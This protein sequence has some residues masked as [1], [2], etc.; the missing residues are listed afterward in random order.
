MNLE[1]YRF[2]FYCYG[3]F[4]RQIINFPQLTATGHVWSLILQGSRV[5]HS[6]RPIV[7]SLCISGLVR[8]LVWILV[9]VLALALVL[10]DFIMFTGRP[11]CIESLV[12]AYQGTSVLLFVHEHVGTLAVHVTILSTIPT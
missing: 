9:L 11:V 4:I 10:A 12:V 1:T 3:D 2:I 7:V 8:P 6:P 5:G